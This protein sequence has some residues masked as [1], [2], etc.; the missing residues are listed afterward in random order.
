MSWDVNAIGSQRF[1]TGVRMFGANSERFEK[2]VPNLSDS[3]L[4]MI[5][6]L[7]NKNSQSCD[8][9]AKKQKYKVFSKILLSS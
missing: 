3:K 8:T 1:G 4:I 2:I 5:Y 6:R 9:S 7:P